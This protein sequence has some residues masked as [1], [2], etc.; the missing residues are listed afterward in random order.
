MQCR[1]DLE[2]G[3]RNAAKSRADAK[4]QIRAVTMSLGS[5]PKP[6]ATTRAGAIATSGVTLSTTATGM[7]ARRITGS[8]ET[9]IARMYATTKPMS[10]PTSATRSVA[11][12]FWR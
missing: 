11:H 2:H 5:G 4:K 6:N 10:R 12:A 9:R 3:L 1:E 7:I 8:S